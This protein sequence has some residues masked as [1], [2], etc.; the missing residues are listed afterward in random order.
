[1]SVFISGGAGFVGSSLARCYR[2]KYPTRRIV[3]FDNLRRRG[4]ELNLRAFKDLDIEF[5]HGDIRAANDFG[6]VQGEFDLFIDAAAEPSAHAGADSSPHY[7]LDTNLVGTLNSLEF[8]R[9]RCGNMIFLSTSRVYSVTAQR[10]IPLREEPTRLSID[11]AATLPEGL[12]GNGISETFDTV[13]F[14]SMYGATKLASELFVQEYC[15]M[16]N[17]RALINRCGVIA[18]PGQWGKV[19]Q[20][21]YTLW[22]A[23]HYFGQQLSYTGFGG[24]GKQVRDL[25]HPDDLFALLEA[26]VPLIEQHTGSVFNA[27][28]GLSGSTSLLEYT[29]LCEE[30]TGQKIDIGSVSETRQ[31]DVPYYVTDS[32]K[33]THTFGWHPQKTPRTIVDDIYAWLA[34]NHDLVSTVFT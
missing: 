10:A 11:T 20:G 18:G 8:A 17:L 2:D 1:M 33:T 30:V 32:A 16:Y 14:R 31:L 5:V 3:A 25:M 12:S 29:A 6:E 13:Q 34:K 22:V 24:T 26:Q 28:G 21:V 23:A 27:G 4:S 15:A 9:K 19:D 7:V